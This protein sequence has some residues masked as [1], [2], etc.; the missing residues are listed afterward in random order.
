M[1]LLTSDQAAQALGV[2]KSTLYAYVSRGLLESVDGPERT[3]RY[4]WEDV[5]RLRM[6]KQRPVEAAENALYGGL[7]S[8][9]SRISTIEPERLC[10]RGQDAVRLSRESTP[11]QVAAL[12]W[13]G[14]LDFPLPEDSQET[15]TG[16]FLSGALGWL[17]EQLE[18]D[19]SA[20]DLSPEGVR[21][22]GWRIYQAFRA[23]LPSHP[24]LDQALILCAD[25][26][27]N[28]STF[29]A[30]VA[31]STGANPYAVVSA[32]LAALSGPKHGGATSQ[33]EALFAEAS[34][35]SPRQAIG[36]RL[37]R[38]DPVAGFGHPL[39]PQG[40]PR[41]R[42]L[43]ED[44]PLA[45]GWIEAG[46]QL[47]NAYPTVD[48]GLVALGLERGAAF[49]LFAAGRCLGWIAHAL[50]QYADGRMIRPRAF[51]RSS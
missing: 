27:L 4:R 7:P 18:Q 15:W 19:W 48:L 41:A 17:A 25:H 26:E 38:G 42:A 32:A 36:E 8:L 30:R 34:A 6:R 43:L 16:P 3:R 39:Y 29:T 23:Q 33:V 45:Q 1:K 35:S 2:S 49:Q 5:E 13:T 10:Y 24:R 44:V 46:Q 22:T 11:R 21:R 12:L 40:D 9:E 31:A 37:R 50:E 20:W 47:L 28:A 14:S 51:H